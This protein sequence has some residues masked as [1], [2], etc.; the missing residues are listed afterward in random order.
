MGNA[1]RLS[2]EELKEVNRVID[3][4]N[5]IHI[6]ILA[7]M[8]KYEKCRTVHPILHWHYCWIHRWELKRLQFKWNAYHEVLKMAQVNSGLYMVPTPT[9]K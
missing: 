5:G 3:Q 2:D 7:E 4:K 8:D 6:Q 9:K 1:Y